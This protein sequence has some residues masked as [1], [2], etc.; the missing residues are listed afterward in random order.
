VRSGLSA[1]HAG[2]DRALPGAAAVITSS[3]SFRPEGRGDA[4]I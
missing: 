1:G 4:R 3:E 2:S